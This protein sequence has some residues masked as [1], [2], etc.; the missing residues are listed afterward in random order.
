MNKRQAKKKRKKEQQKQRMADLYAAIAE[1]PAIARK[2]GEGLREALDKLS[3]A[4]SEIN[5]VEL[6]KQIKEQREQEEQGEQ[7]GAQN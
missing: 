1:L 7:D 2:V 6:C 4:L 3:E 5:V